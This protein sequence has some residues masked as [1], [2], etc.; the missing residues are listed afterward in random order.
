MSETLY[1]AHV[2][3]AELEKVDALAASLP[4]GSPVAVLLQGMLVSLSKGKNL[5]VLETDKCFTPNQAAELLGMSRP[6]LMK[7]LKSGEMEAE[8]VGSHHRTPAS[9]LL[10][11]IDRRERAK[12]VIAA[13]Y[14]APN[15][16]ESALRDAATPLTDEDLAALRSI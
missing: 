14:G 6:H 9:E 1:A 12:A 11:Y 4:Q 2:S 7:L 16:V 3:A 5:A 15:V 13:A 10:A 8:Q